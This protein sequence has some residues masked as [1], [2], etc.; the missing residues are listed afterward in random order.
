MPTEREK[1]LAGELYDPLDAEL[2]A[3]RLRARELCHAINSA[4][5]ANET[6][7]RQL[8]EKLLAAGADAAWI[9]PPFYCDYGV[10]IYLGRE[11]FFNFNCVVLDVCEVRIGADLYGHTS[12]GGR[13]SPPRGIG[14]AHYDRRRCVD[15]RRRDP[16]PR[17]ERRL[18]DRHR[19]GQRRHARHPSQRLRRRQPL[20]HNPPPGRSRRKLE[21]ASTR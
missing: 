14:Q 4:S 1:M 20:P 13:A 6:L 11:V 8:L 10:H 7:H 15:R 18:A 3:M 5:P 2:V 21:L 19:R 17:R 9:Q 16:L 12:A